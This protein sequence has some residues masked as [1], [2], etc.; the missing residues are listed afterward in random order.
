[1]IEEEKVL[2]EYLSNN[3]PLI[4]LAPTYKKGCKWK[5]EDAGDEIFCDIED[6]DFIAKVNNREI[7]TRSRD[8]FKVNRKITKVL[9][10]KGEIKSKHTILKILEI[11][12]E[13]DLFNWDNS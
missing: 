13:K 11:T 4:L 8:V 6:P 3:D 2:S 7:A 1:M 9:N 10:K 5:F 12:E